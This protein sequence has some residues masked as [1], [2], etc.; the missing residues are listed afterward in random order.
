MAGSNRS[1]NLR[2]VSKAIP[3]GTIAAQMTTSITCK[4]LIAANLIIIF[5]VFRRTGY[6]ILW[7]DC[8]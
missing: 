4:F 3:F 6:F 2:D 1:G 7:H 5:Y 8:V